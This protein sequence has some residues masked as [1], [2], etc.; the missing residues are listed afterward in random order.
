MNKSNNLDYFTLYIIFSIAFMLIT[1]LVI[2]FA[3]PSTWLGE[4]LV[5][6]NLLNALVWLAIN[7]VNRLREKLVSHR[8][9]H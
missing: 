6:I 8:D 5:T 7:V 9:Q 1:F 2:L 3:K 4:V